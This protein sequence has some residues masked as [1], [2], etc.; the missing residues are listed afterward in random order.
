MTPAPGPPPSI[1]KRGDAQALAREAEGLRAVA[2]RPWAPA[3]LEAGHGVIVT[4]LVEGAPRRLAGLS[5]ADARRLGAVLRE[6]HDLRADSHGGLP[7]WPAPVRSLA[8]YRSARLADA[9]GGLA[10][11]GRP[12][13]AMALAIGPAPRGEGPFRLLHGDLV[14]QNVLWP[15]SGPV[16][17]DWEF[18]RLG[19][20]AEDLAYLLA[21]NDVPDAVAAAVLAGHGDAEAAAG[22]PW[23][24]P[25]VMADAAGWY[26]RH[27]AADAAAPLLRR[28]GAA[29]G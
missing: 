22:V 18:H 1:E 17:V 12:L 25:V 15:P 13:A 11:A 28:L 6:L 8:A 16:L 26:L 5:E 24:R 4:T 27:G 14:E 23:W 2:G 3:L 20:P 29:A 10:E 7:A 9:L 21:V 19:D